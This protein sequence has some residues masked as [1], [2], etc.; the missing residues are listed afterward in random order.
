MPSSCSLSAPP[1]VTSV[2]KKGA[3]IHVWHSGFCGCH[4]EDTSLDS[5]ALVA[6][7]ASV[8]GFSGM[9]ANEETILNWLS[10]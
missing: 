6:S 9:V 3:C 7:R 8:H 10:H 4:V 5:L 2:S 1:L